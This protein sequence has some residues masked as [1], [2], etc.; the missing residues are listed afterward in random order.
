MSDDVEV[1]ISGREA[2]LIL[3]YGYPFPDQVPD[4]EA[5][6]GKK[7]YHQVVI[8]GFWLEAIVGDLSRSIQEVGSSPLQEELNSLCVMLE[9][10]MKYSR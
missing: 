6:A 5:V 10:A 4:F 8:G 1:E 2:N 7:G 3:K 9:S